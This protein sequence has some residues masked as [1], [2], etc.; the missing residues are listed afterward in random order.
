MLRWLSDGGYFEEVVRF[1][2]ATALALDESEMVAF[3]AL[4]ELARPVLL[5]ELKNST[6]LHWGER[7]PSVATWIACV[8]EAIEKYSGLT[9]G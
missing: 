7:R 5:A 1:I 6:V 4:G 8:R 2:Q 3:N 9:A